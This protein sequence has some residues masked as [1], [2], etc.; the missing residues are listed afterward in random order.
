MTPRDTSA[1]IARVQIER[2]RA[3]SGARRLATA[4]ALT[5]LAREFA[6]AGIRER[7]PGASL[8]QLD[9]ELCAL[10]FGAETASRV[11]EARLRRGP[12]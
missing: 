4:F 6:M 3:G 5:S 1:E 11:R 9:Y 8:E 2:L 12:G 7:N 10:L